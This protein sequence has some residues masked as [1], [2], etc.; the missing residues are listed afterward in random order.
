MKKFISLN[1][2]KKIILYL[3]FYGQISKNENTLFA[4]VAFAVRDDYQ[5]QG[6]GFELLEYLTIIAKKAGLHGFTAEVLM[7]NQPMLHVFEKMGFDIHRKI[8]EGAYKLI[9]R[10]NV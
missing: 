7:E 3:V 8:E 4:E 2:T 1:K 5:N 6:I 9:M 10:F